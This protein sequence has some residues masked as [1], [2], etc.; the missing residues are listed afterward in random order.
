M[1]TNTS[2]G[3]WASYG[4][5]YNVSIEAT[6]ADAVNGGDSDWRERLQSSGAFDRIVSGY[7]AAIDA[8]LPGDVALC[9]DEFIGPAR[10]S[11]GR[12]CGWGWPRVP[13]P[14]PGLGR[15]WC[16]SGWC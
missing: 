8:A 6:V 3:S 4:D 10:L 16:G 7:R 15:T 2:Y 9:G 14:R 1:K 12:C 13:S 5:R 11:G